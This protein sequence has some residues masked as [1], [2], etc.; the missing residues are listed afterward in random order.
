MDSGLHGPYFS[1]RQRSQRSGFHKKD[2][3]AT[4]VRYKRGHSYKPWGAG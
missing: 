4:E 3:V 2:E 1:K